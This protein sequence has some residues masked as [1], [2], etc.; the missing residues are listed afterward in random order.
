[1]TH[2]TLRF[3]A[4]AAATWISLSAGAVSAAE[5]WPAKPIRL[6][7]PFAPGGTSDA[8]GRQ[9]AQALTAELHQS[10]V[11]ENRAGAGGTIGAG[12][13][14]HAAP[15]G[16][17]FLIATT[18]H[19]LAPAIY[20]SLSYDF[21]RDLD[22][23]SLTASAPNVLV[24]NSSVPA[25]S[26]KELIEY[27]KANPGK[28]NYGSAGV[29]STEHL[30]A[31]LFGLMSDTKLTHVPYKGGALAMTDL[32]A[33]QVQMVI[34]PSAGALG[35]VKS[36]MVKAL[37]V[38]TAQRSPAYPDVPTMSE[39]G[40]TGYEFATWYAVMTP[41]GTPEDV[42]Q[43]MDAALAKVLQ[44]PALIKSLAEQGVMVDYKNT[45][46]LAGY[47]GT[48]TEKWGKVAKESGM[49]AE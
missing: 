10:V 15:D 43:R 41:H 22:P 20:K 26:V 34:E 25:K 38:T 11:V 17:T 32:A 47:I 19:T 6:I 9:L 36:G 29:G 45:S 4:A 44:T 23:I 3:L 49:K 2:K 30:S 35:L 28:V 40:L 21:I 13:V 12:V 24:I 16:Y 8:V 1:M 46:Q 39:A 5:T 31:A 42:K 18:A 48:E 27:A 7:V 33:G 37:A 14:S